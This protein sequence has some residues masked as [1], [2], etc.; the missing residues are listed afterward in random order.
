MKLRLPWVMLTVLGL[1]FFL[2]PGGCNTDETDN[3]TTDAPPEVD[4]TGSWT[5]T[6]TTASAQGDFNFTMTMDADGEVEGMNTRLGRFTGDVTGNRFTIDST[7]FFATI[8]R[9]GRTMTGTFTDS[10][11]G[12]VATVECTKN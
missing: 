1:A 9:N 6:Y 3:P 11:S 7:D 10:E 12:D 4:V 5:G 2:C 8:S